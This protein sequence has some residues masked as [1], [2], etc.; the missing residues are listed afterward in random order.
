[1][2]LRVTSLI[3]I[4]ESHVVEVDG[5]TKQEMMDNAIEEFRRIAENLH[6]WVDFDSA[7]IEDTEGWEEVE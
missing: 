5:D 3:T 1:M 6:G 4:C 2:K 7:E